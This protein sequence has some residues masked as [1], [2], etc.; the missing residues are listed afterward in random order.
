VLWSWVP[1]PSD[2]EFHRNVVVTKN[3]VFVSTDQAV[4]AIDLVTHKPVWTWPTP[5]SISLSGDGYLFIVEGA[6]ESTGHLHA[7]KVY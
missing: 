6:S 2:T 1:A 4:Y 7:F 5:G 3:L